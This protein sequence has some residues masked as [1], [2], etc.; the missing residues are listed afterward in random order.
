M[1]NLGFLD[2]APKLPIY[3]DIAEVKSWPDQNIITKLALFIYNPDI[4]DSEVID[5]INMDSTGSILNTIK[6][7]SHV[8]MVTSSPRFHG[9]FAE[10]W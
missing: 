3:P 7:T 1:V 6:L 5:V 2:I 9:T 4:A 8:T 10:K